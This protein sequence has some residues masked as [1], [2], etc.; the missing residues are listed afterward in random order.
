[1]THTTD[2]DQPG[3]FEGDRYERLRQAAEVLGADEGI[4]SAEAPYNSEGLRAFANTIQQLAMFTGL[5]DEDSNF[6]GMLLLLDFPRGPQHMAW[7][8]GNL[9][10]DTPA[11]PHEYDDEIAVIA[12]YVE[13]LSML[14]SAFRRPDTHRVLTRLAADA[15][16]AY[17]AV[18]EAPGNAGDYLRAARDSI[19][20]AI[21]A[22]R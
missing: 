21:E 5:T 18:K 4:A 22:T 9:L 13:V 11:V 1:M 7:R 16:E 12:T 14:M 17:D 20:D 15:A 10:S 6:A 2:T 3:R 8:V 19:A